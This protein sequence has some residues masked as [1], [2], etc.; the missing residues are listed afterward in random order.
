VKTV[1]ETITTTVSEPAAPQPPPPPPPPSSDSN[2]AG[3]GD[4]ITLA[5]QD[6]GSEM[7]VK[8]LQVIYPATPSDQYDSP[9]T[10]HVY[11]A[12]RIRLTNVGTVAYNDSP[13][14]GAAIIDSKDQQYDSTYGGLEPA[15]HSLIIGAGDSRVGFISF[16]VPEGTKLRT[17]QFTLDSGFGPETGEW[18]L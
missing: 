13:S 5:G 10:G 4:A 15:L 6:S 12:V 1:S 17:F 9:S 16:E 18:N 14:N 2:N 11:G 3:V 7:R 8:V